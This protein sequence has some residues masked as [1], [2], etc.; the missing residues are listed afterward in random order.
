MALAAGAA[1]TD[2]ALG[3]GDA[4]LVGHQVDGRPAQPHQLRDAQTVLEGQPQHQ[5]V[6][7]AVATMPNRAAHQPVHL[8]C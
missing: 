8:V 4:Q 5:G 6:P 3:A 1:G 7:P 2:L